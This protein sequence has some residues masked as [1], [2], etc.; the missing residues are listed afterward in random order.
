MLNT[1]WLG[2]RGGLGKLPKG[3]RCEA[4]KQEWLERFSYQLACEDCARFIA[5]AIVTFDKEMPDLDPAD[6][7]LLCLGCTNQRDRA[8]N[9]LLI[10]ETA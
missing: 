10:Q 5:G 7:G 8:A 6:S 1:R 3:I 4:P 2:V 9:A